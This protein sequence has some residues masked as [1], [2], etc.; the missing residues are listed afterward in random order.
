MAWETSQVLFYSNQLSEA[1]SIQVATSIYQE[2]INLHNSLLIALHIPNKHPYI[3]LKLGDPAFLILNSQ[4]T[5]SVIKRGRPVVDVRTNQEAPYPWCGSSLRVLF[6]YPDESESRRGFLLNDNGLIVEE[7]EDSA[8]CDQATP[9]SSFI[10]PTYQNG[11]LDVI[12]G[13]IKSKSPH[14]QARSLISFHFLDLTPDS[15]VE[16]LRF[17]ELSQT[18][19]LGKEINDFNTLSKM[20]IDPTSISSNMLTSLIANVF[21]PLLGLIITFILVKSIIDCLLAR[22]RSGYSNVKTGLY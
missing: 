13:K 9:P 18:S 2:C 11:S 14:Y 6:R 22:T 21:L 8:S 1:S 10:V 4:P 5:Y 7:D 17:Q 20:F 3:S 16:R 19:F 15:G 12:S